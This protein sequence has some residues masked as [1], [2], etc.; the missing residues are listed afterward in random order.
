M[1]EADQLCRRVAFLSDGRIIALD[2]PQALK[3]RYGRRQ[4][5]VLLADQSRQV[6]ALDQVGAARKLT[7]WM[8]AG[9]VLTIHSQEATL[10]DV[11]VQL[12]GRGLE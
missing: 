8:D 6:L 1:E 12:A 3:L 11:F 4:V 2:T 5:S 10:E 7:E 9:Q